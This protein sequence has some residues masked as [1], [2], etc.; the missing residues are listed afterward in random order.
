MIGTVESC[1]KKPLACIFFMIV[2]EADQHRRTAA[3]IHI[4]V[5]GGA[6]LPLDRA[7][8]VGLIVN[9]LVTNSLKYAF[10]GEG[11]T[12]RVASTMDPEVSEGHLVV[13]DKGRGMGAPREGGLGLKLIRAFSD[14]LDGQVEQEPV[15]KGTRTC[16]RFPLPL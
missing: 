5:E 3:R 13:E 10:G 12:I 8:P 4:Q 6:Q 11:G 14:Q 15:E 1:L 16:V 9:E 7:V 2:G